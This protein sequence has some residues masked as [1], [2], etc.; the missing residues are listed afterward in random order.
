MHIS[1]KKGI[2]PSSTNKTTL[3]KESRKEQLKINHLNRNQKENSVSRKL[4]PQDPNGLKNEL[5]LK[6]KEINKHTSIDNSD[7]NQKMTS[8]YK[9]RSPEQANQTLNNFNQHSSSYYKAQS[10]GFSQ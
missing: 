7:L 8:K 5:L 3:Y 4:M 6:E 9:V 10:K 1:K 2:N